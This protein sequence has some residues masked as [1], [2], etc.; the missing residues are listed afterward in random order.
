MEREVHKRDRNGYLQ[1]MEVEKR[2]IMNSITPKPP[3]TNRVTP[4]LRRFE[5]T[6]SKQ[7][8]MKK[9]CTGGDPLPNPEKYGGASI[10]TLLPS[11]KQDRVI[12]I[13]NEHK[14][15]SLKDELN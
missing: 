3:N 12:M 6:E 1:K 14:L 11:I 15:K 5:Q 8:E 2:T 10:R 13:Q 7:F 9:L 4:I